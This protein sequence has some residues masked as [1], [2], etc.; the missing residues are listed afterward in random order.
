VSEIRS[1]T[2]PRRLGR[3]LAGAG[4]FWLVVAGQGWAQGIRPDYAST[5]GFAAALQADYAKRRETALQ[6]RC[7]RNVLSE[8]CGAGFGTNKEDETT[9]IGQ[10]VSSM[11]SNLARELVSLKQYPH[12]VVGRIAA[13]R[14]K[15]TLECL[16]FDEGGRFRVVF[17]SIEETSPGTLH[18]VDFSA[19]GFPRSF[20]VSMRERL[21]FSGMPYFSPLNDDEARVERAMRPHLR[22]GHSFFNVLSAGDFDGAFSLLATLPADVRALPL[23]RE[24]RTRL[25]AQGSERAAKSLA[26]ERAWA[27]IYEDDFDRFIEV[28]H[29]RDAT[30]KL[31]TLDAV[32]QSAHQLPFLQLIKVDLLIELGRLEEA[33][34]LAIH[35]RELNPLL[36]GA[37]LAVIRTSFL[38]REEPRALEALVEAAHIWKPEDLLRFLEND[39]GAPAWKE[40]P[41]FQQWAANARR[42]ATT[43]KEQAAAPAP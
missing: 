13:I 12:L 4:L 29:G 36:I 34:R 40:S 27:P 7:N 1:D 42:P 6:E 14:G 38:T 10:L 3:W 17:L 26:E 22:V 23:W 39:P 15:R 37:H 31:S 30:V 28:S 21:L 32:L 8:R 9:L 19:L 35:L 24:L 16:F 20:V 41:R 11:A 2:P 5:Y 33:S 43:V 25:I 18:I